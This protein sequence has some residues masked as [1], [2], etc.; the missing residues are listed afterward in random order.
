MV[1]DWR[2]GYWYVIVGF[3][4]LGLILYLT[5][6]I[7][8]WLLPRDS[9]VQDSGRLADLLR[10]Q[11]QGL[12]EIWNATRDS[13]QADALRSQI[14]LNHQI[15]QLVSGARH[16]Y[17]PG[18]GG[19][20]GQNFS[21]RRHGKLFQWQPR[22][23]RFLL[24]ICTSGQISNHLIC[25]EKHMFFAALLDRTLVLPDPSVD[26]SYE[27][28]LDI[29]HI[30][31]CL[32]EKTLLTFHEF[33]AKNKTDIRLLC[34]MSGCYLDKDHEKKIKALG[35][36][37]S[38]KTDAWPEEASLKGYPSHPRASEFVAKFSC[39]DEV[40]GIGDVFYS[41]VESE[42]VAQIGGPLQH[43]C[44]TIIRPNRLILLTAQRFVQTFLGSNF[45]ALHFRRHG[46]LKF[47]NVKNESCFFPIPQA[48][49]CILRKIEEAKPR[50]IYISTDAAESEITLL[51]QLLGP[52][53][54][55]IQRPQHDSREKWDAI[56]QRKGL[57]AD[58]EVVAMLDK[59]ICAMAESFIGTPGST[60]TDDIVRLRKEWGSSNSCDGVLCQGQHPN[61]IA[62]TD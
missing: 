45:M 25:L 15:Q 47:C 19:C 18:M 22:E 31:S 50:V 46:F 14:E 58:N 11:E 33:L 60:F 21:S 53:V 62:D 10:R 51:Q 17:D 38:S 23:D 30:R 34:Y 7:E 54:P 8:H 3:L 57:L 48:A 61:F 44:K 37:W 41:D 20:Q 9:H 39:E 12:F 49:S 29:A 55:M 16:G 13:S 5:S 24:V 32:G 1:G 27:K 56:L 26:Y 52:D 35:L 43:S 59:T 40:L 4:T 42:L 36:S 2:K 6:D 28:T